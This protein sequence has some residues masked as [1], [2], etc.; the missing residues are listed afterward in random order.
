MTP[1]DP[2]GYIEACRY[3]ILIVG[4]SAV[5]VRARGNRIAVV[6]K[7]A[8]ERMRIALPMPSRSHAKRAAAAVLRVLRRAN[9]D[10]EYDELVERIAREYADSVTRESEPTDSDGEGQD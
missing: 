4:G 5:K 8:T 1:L 2:K 9:N 7:K 10:C 3:R 6:I